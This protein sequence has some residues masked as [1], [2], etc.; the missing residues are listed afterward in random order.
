MKIK[1]SH[2]PVCAYENYRALKLTL[3]YLFHAIL[4]IIVF[5]PL[6]FAFTSSFR[7]LEDIY[8]YISPLSLETFIPKN[9]TL[10]AY[11]DIFVEFKFG[12]S[13]FNSVF[14][15]LVTVLAGILINGMAGFA[16]AKFKFPFKRV[17]FVIVL[18]TFMVPFELISINLYTIMIDFK[19]I[20]SFMA[21]IIPSIPNGMVIFLFRQ[22]FQG[23]PDYLLESA[24]IDGLNWA[25]TFFKIVLPNSKAICISSGLV[26]FINQWEAFLWPV[27]V[28]R[29]KEMQTIQIALNSFRTQ[30]TKMWNNIF[31]ASLIAFMIPI[32]LIIPLQKFYVEGITSAGTK[33]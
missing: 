11:R 23:F 21:L 7:P 6:V 1:F 2:L 24:K 33:E 17:L 25:Q 29:T 13:V 31:A 10:G 16:F 3:F 20:D 5:L 30:Y 9:F 22:Y 28:T 8:K 4:I 27:L 18:L 15:A 14:I 32:L 19:W 12:R 26:L